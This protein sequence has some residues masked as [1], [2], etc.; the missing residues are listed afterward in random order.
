MTGNCLGRNGTEGRGPDPKICLPSAV[1]GNSSA[2]FLLLPLMCP[3]PV[4]G[5]SMEL[6]ASLFPAPP[7]S[8]P[9]S[10]SSPGP[11]SGLV[12]KNCTVP[13][14]TVL[15]GVR[16]CLPRTAVPSPPA[17]RIRFL[18]HTHTQLWARS[19]AHTISHFSFIIFI[20]LLVEKFY[21]YRNLNK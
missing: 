4:L 15:K 6:M 16:S 18:T 9:P 21:I 3:H 19:A 17:P 11:F 7:G 5:H 13:V 1:S 20:R 8:R 14:Y 2:A 10:L 12:Y